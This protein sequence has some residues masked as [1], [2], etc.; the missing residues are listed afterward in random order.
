VT[1]KV[2]KVVYVL[3]TIVLGLIAL[4]GIA[5]SFRINVVLGIVD[6]FILAPLGFFIYLAL[7]RIALEIFIVIFRISDDLRAIRDRG[8]ALR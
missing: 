2:V 6:L 7:W 5:Y 3:I 8:G 4:V 1:P